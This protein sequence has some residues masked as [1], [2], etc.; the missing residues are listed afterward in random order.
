MLSLF[1]YMDEINNAQ[2]FRGVVVC[3][4]NCSFTFESGSIYPKKHDVMVMRVGRI[5]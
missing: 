5:K 1:D 4:N 2:Q 3:I